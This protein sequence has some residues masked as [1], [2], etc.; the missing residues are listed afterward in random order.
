MQNIML[1]A[2]MAVLLY[3]A[4][5]FYGKG[6]SASGF[7]NLSSDE[8][9]EKMQEPNTEVI[10]VRTSGEVAGGYIKGA[11]HFFDYTGG[12]FEQKIAKLDKEKTYLVYCRSGARSSAACG[13]LAKNGFMR[14]GNLRGGIMGWNG[15]IAKK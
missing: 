15:D 1:L 8:F 5:R 12:G 9:K 13:I 6:G 14:V 4:F 3:I 11:K 7:V 10:D 2:A